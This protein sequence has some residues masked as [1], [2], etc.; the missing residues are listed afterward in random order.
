MQ[1][2][3]ALLRGEAFRVTDKLSMAEVQRLAENANNPNP[4]VA[5]PARD[6]LTVLA[7]DVDRFEDRE[8]W[9]WAQ[10]LIR[11]WIARSR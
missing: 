4:L 2:R 5:G 6:R 11:S 3:M 7:Q 1:I 8:T 9:L 10:H